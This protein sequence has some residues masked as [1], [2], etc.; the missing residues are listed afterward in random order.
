MTRILKTLGAACAV[1]L[2]A[3]GC[4]KEV[5]PQSNYVSGDQIQEDPAAF[6]KLV[7]G[8]CSPM[9]SNYIVMK[10]WPWD[11]GY[12]SL[13]CERD[14]MGQD[15]VDADNFWQIWYTVHS[16]L[17]AEY[18]GCQLPWSFYYQ[19]INRANLVIGM[20]PDYT[21]ES[22]IK[23]H[24][25]GIAYAMR[26]FAYMDLARLYQNTY[27]GNE[28]KPT[29]PIVLETTTEEEKANN[30]RVSNKR[31]YEQIIEDLDKAEICLMDYQRTDKT[32]PNINVVYGLKARAY[33]TME[34]FVK[35]EEYA[36]KAQSGYT[37][38]SQMEWL[39][40]AT[41]FNNLQSSSWIWGMQQTADD[42]IIK[43]YGGLYSW[44]G[45]FSCEQSFGYAGLDGGSFPMIDA[46]LYSTIPATDFRKQ[47]FLAPNDAG[48]ATAL[49]KYTDFN[50][51]NLGFKVTNLPPYTSFKFRPGGQGYTDY[52]TGCA[53]GIPLMRVEEMM[54]IEAEAIGMQ[55]GRESEGKSKLESFGRLRNPN[56][57]I[58]ALVPFRDQVWW[59]R[60][61]E[62]WG[63]G[64]ATFDIKRLNKGIIRSYKGTNH[65]AKYRFN[66]TGV[67]QW[68]NYVIIAT[69]FDNNLGLGENNPTPVSPGGDSPEHE[70]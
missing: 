60:R 15:Y 21:S 55:A 51:T 48:N 6:S 46:H 4:I 57:T 47:A 27:V 38:M 66:T 49:A 58:D 16:A 17:G 20:V 62:L 10:E 56:Y 28:D 67:P 44:I 68:M 23:R 12:P 11:F 52:Q 64:F 65:L 1:L 50:P 61:V 22:D 35:A 9:I 40:K 31:I 32:E 63:E 5:E 45:S 30:P 36:V 3:V 24:G 34:N 25:A 42:P 39:D 69:E 37:P 53:V 19:L 14:F 41:G 8:I 33:L 59:Q 29:V 18:L 54:L 13:M 43:N 2:L 70:F 26:A 7:K